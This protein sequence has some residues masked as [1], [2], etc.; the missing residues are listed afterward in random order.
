M[1][2]KEKYWSLLLFFHPNLSL[3][4]YYSASSF[5]IC[6]LFQRIPTH[7]ILFSLFLESLTCYEEE[8]LVSFLL[9]SGEAVGVLVVDEDVPSTD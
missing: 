6:R 5:L 8:L 4:P 3:L 2:I 9:Y 7:S 1:W